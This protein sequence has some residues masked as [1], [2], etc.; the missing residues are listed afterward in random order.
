MTLYFSPEGKTLRG[1]HHYYLYNIYKFRYQTICVACRNILLHS[2]KFV[3][4]VSEKSLFII[5]EI[6]RNVWEHLILRN[7]SPLYRIHCSLSNEIS[8]SSLSN[9]ITLRYR[10]LSNV[11]RVSCLCSFSKH[12]YVIF[13]NALFITFYFL[14]HWFSHKSVRP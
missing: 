3:P 11:S 7:I 4:A 1:L 12:Y 8:I 6:S 13:S 5:G 14:M 9:G 10:P 2:S